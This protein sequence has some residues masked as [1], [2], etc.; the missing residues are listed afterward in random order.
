MVSFWIE[1]NKKK[2]NPPLYILLLSIMPLDNPISI[3]FRRNLI[4]WE[5]QERET[6]EREN[7]EIKK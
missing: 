5:V 3:G 7:D 2:M 1:L 4:P 6:K